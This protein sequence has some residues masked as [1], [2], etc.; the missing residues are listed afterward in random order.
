[1]FNQ[2]KRHM[3]KRESSCRR[4]VEELFYYTDLQTSEEGIA[5]DKDDLFNQEQWYLWGL[6]RRQLLIAAASAGGVVGGGAGM[7]IDGMTGGMTGG[8]GTLLSGIGG[9]ST[10]LP[11]GRSAVS[12][13]AASC[14][15]TVHPATRTSLSWCSAGRCSTIA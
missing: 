10:I 7:A 11:S 4:Q 15:P 13:A 14:S 9:A 6:N 12:P 5:L 8:L 1:L 3:V 2:Y